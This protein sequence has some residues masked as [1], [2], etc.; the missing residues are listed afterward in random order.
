[1]SKDSSHVGVNLSTR[2]HGGR[3]QALLM[4][5]IAW[6]VG[7]SIWF[8]RF[9]M[10]NHDGITRPMLWA[11]LPFT[12]LDLIDP[13]IERNKPTWS[14]FFLLER[15]PFLV[16]AALIWVGAWGIGSL[17]LR[18]AKVRL[19]GCESLFFSLCVGLSFASLTV[20]GLGL[21]GLMSCWILTGLFLAAGWL[22]TASSQTCGPI[23][24]HGFC[25]QI[26]VRIWESELG[27]PWMHGSFFRRPTSW[28]D[29]AAK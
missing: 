27:H 11:N 18:I 26:H 21:T 25:Y 7:F 17:V 3:S 8:Y 6:V 13:P 29:D 20:L 4:I 22:R 23:P 12:L 24:Q 19:R 14:W 10:P 5:A 9:G 2:Q 15:I 1:M 16:V 28:C